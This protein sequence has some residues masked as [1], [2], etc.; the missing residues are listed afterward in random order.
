MALLSRGK[1]LRSLP[2]T[3]ALL[4]HLLEDVTQEQAENSWD[5]EWNVVYMVCHLRDLEKAYVERLRMMLSEDNPTFPANDPAELAERNNYASADLRAA[6]AEFEA[7]RRE[8][9]RI[10]EGLTP[11]QWERRGQHPAFGE[12]TILTQAINNAIHDLDHIEQITRALGKT[13]VWR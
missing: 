4:R 13:Q 1:A 10:V 8:F 2:K 6:L 12:T 9:I 3:M 7:L 11:D 5:K